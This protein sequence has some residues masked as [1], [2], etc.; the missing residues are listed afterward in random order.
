MRSVVVI[1]VCSFLF[2]CLSV[3]SFVSRLLFMC[4]CCVFVHVPACSGNMSIQVLPIMF[5][6]W[7]YDRIRSFLFGDQILRVNLSL[8]RTVV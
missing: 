6:N 2:M 3:S 5:N 1:R 8:E 4:V 7:V